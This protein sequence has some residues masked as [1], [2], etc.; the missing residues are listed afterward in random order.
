MTKHFR[1][2][3]FD[4]FRNKSPFGSLHEHALKVRE[5]IAALRETTTAFVAHE[6]DRTHEL[7]MIVSALELEADE[8]KSNIRNHL[9]ANVRMPV[10]KALFLE[11]LASQ[12]GI[13]DKAEDA[14]I[15]MSMRPT[16]LPDDMGVDMMALLDKVAETIEAYQDAVANLEDLLGTGFVKR[17]REE[18]K[19]LVHRVHAL[20][21]ETDVLTRELSRKLL[22]PQ[23]EKTMGAIGV[24]HM[25]KLTLQISKIADH[26]ENAADRL[27]AMLSR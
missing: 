23:A 21:H 3:I 13:L 8:I 22:T 9:P 11:A 19:E 7:A 12:D 25:L 4:T 16:Q 20:E 18:E 24:Y 5:C 17:E 1:A 6:H 10:D 15:W 14:A 26:A 2:P 27:R